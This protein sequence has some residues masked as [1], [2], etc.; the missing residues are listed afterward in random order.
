MN[1]FVGGQVIPLSNHSGLIQ[2]VDQVVAL[3][4]VYKEWHNR[5]HKDNQVP[6]V[7][8]VTGSCCEWL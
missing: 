2:W 7:Y 5:N 6:Q 4:T 3:H 8:T 1:E